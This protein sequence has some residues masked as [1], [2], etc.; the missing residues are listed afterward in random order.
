M[1][2]DTENPMRTEKH[3][4]VLKQATISKE[5]DDN[6]PTLSNNNSYNS[7]N[8]NVSAKSNN[9]EDNDSDE[10]TKAHHLL[11]K[12][13]PFLKPFIKKWYNYKLPP[14]PEHLRFITNP[15]EDFFL[16]KE[17]KTA[18][19]TEFQAGIVSFLACIYCIPI[20]SAQMNLAGYSYNTATNTCSFLVAF[21][22]FLM[23]LITNTPIVIAPPA[24]LSIYIFNNMQENELTAN[25]G[26]KAIFYSGI[27]LFLIGV[28]QNISLLVTGMIPSSLQN[29][30]SI[31]IGLFTTFQ[32]LTAID[33]VVRGHQMY[34][35]PG[36]IS[37]EIIICI[38]AVII[39][40]LSN[41]YRSK[42]SNILGLLWAAF[43]WW[44]SQN[45]WP[46]SWGER[47]TFT[48]S[49]IDKITN[50]DALLLVFELTILIV[51][52]TYGL[53]A[54]LLFRAELS[55]EKGSIKRG[56]IIMMLVGFMNIVSGGMNGPPLSILADSSSSIQA[57]GR[58]GFCSIICSLLFLATIFFGPL[59]SSLPNAATSS[60]L[61]M[62]GLSYFRNIS[63]IDFVDSKYA[64][65]AFL[66]IVLIPFTQSTIVGVGFGFTLHAIILIISG[67]S[68]IEFN[69]FLD[70]YFPT[71]D[72]IEDEEIVLK[73][74]VKQAESL[75]HSPSKQQPKENIILDIPK[76]L[77]NPKRRIS[78]VE[79]VFHVPTN[80][81]SDSRTSTSINNFF[82]STDAISSIDEAL[83][84]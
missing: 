48:S 14:P 81:N 27:F 31:G 70:H 79:R 60:V 82:F 20:V 73:H 49:T 40:A 22:T 75:V 12:V 34:L 66:T 50:K 42:Y 78:V 80:P 84:Y 29:A 32:G 43:F 6:L 46:T 9:A 35:A 26:S 17:R 38:S 72:I 59:L 61:I 2:I 54:T 15:I 3:S 63:K 25:Q 64:M 55:K 62:I 10:D 45:S 18:I 53:A 56:R 83:I 71:D 8:N 13:F 19:E 37:D 28:F 7:H 74:L 16:M 69:K 51:L 36:K 30:T 1:D 39:I 58:T 76:V 5:N 57:G 23:G 47:P 41:F 52:T 33:L 21:G 65:P 77:K 24:A 44:T 67:D 68:Q 11:Y 4:D